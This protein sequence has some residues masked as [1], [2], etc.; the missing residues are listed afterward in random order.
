MISFHMNENKT[1][2]FTR[3][4]YCTSAKLAVDRSRMASSV[5]LSLHA[6]RSE[7]MYSK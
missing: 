5:L 3:S 2:Y 6:R 7:D 4:Q 1:S